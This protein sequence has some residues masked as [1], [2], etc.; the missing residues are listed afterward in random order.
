MYHL[1]T[2]TNTQLIF[3]K[4]LYRLCKNLKFSSQWRQINHTISKNVFLIHIIITLVQVYKRFEKERVSLQSKDGKS[5]CLVLVCI[6]TKSKR[7]DTPLVWPILAEYQRASLTM[8]FLSGDQVRDL[9]SYNIS[10]LDKHDFYIDN[11]H[12][13]KYLLMQL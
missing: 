1:K 11:L 5:T 13:E 8:L 10:Y 4:P 2:S 3:S 6:P 12:L 7:I 9:I